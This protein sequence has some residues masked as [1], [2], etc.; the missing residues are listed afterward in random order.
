MFYIAFL[1]TFM[2]LTVLGA[3]DIL[4]ASALTLVGLMLGL[5][6]IAIFAAK[7]RSFFQSEAAVKR[8]NLSAGSIMVAAG[9]YL[10]SRN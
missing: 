9:A 7:A 4:L 3:G 8:L 1:P 6:M 10:A 5:M 2:D